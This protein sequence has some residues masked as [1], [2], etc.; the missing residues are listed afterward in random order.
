M[1]FTDMTLQQQA[2]ISAL[3]FLGRIG[4]P[5]PPS[6]FD[7]QQKLARIREAVLEFDRTVKKDPYFRQFF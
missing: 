7:R 1:K 5:N 2:L 6:E 4:S 3:E